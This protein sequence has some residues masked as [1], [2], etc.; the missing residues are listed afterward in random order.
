MFEENVEET[1][2]TSR[3]IPLGYFFVKQCVRETNIPLIERE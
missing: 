1:K 2:T 3:S